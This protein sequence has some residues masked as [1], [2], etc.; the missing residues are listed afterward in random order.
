MCLVTRDVDEPISTFKLFIL[1][2]IGDNLDL[3]SIVRIEDTVVA[4]MRW[5]F[6]AMTAKKMTMCTFLDVSDH[7]YRDLLWD[8]FVGASFP[9]SRRK[10]TV[11]APTLHELKTL[12]RISTRTPLVTADVRLND[13]LSGDDESDLKLDWHYLLSKVDLPLKR[14]TFFELE[15]GTPSIVY[16]F[17]S[18]GNG[19]NVASNDDDFFLVM[20]IS[21]EGR[22]KESILLS[23]DNATS[24]TTKKI[25][26]KQKVLT[27]EKFINSILDWIWKHTA[28]SF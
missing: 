9:S 15:E 2:T 24:N 20:E 1:C 5:E 7:L 27:V 21:R 14:T 8:S 13:L 23:R 19:S 18:N 3:D 10:H 6:I 16:V 17:Y 12:C 25:S 26:R 28:F 11:R 4:M 22:L